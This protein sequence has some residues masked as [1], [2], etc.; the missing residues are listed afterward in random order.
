V[1][2]FSTHDPMIENAAVVAE[3]CA[4]IA[5]TCS[6]LR[7]NLMVVTWRPSNSLCSMA[8]QS[9]RLNS[10]LLVTPLPVNQTLSSRCFM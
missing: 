2:E 6:V 7:R 3:C 4:L 10:S 9:G 5:G 1:K 8:R